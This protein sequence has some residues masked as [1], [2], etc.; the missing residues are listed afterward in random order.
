MAEASPSLRVAHVYKD[1]HPVRGGIEH[2]V[3]VLAEAQA[4]AGHAVSVLVANPAGGRT[5]TARENGVEVIRAGRWVTWASTPLSPTLPVRLLR[6][7]GD[8]AHLH[9]PHPP[10]EVALLVG[11][12]ARR[13]VLTVHCDIVRQRR[14]ARLYRPLLARVLRRVDR[15]VVTSHLVRD[16]LPW[17]GPV[18]DRVRVVPLGVDTDRFRPDQVASRGRLRQFWGVPE[19]VPVLLFVGRLRHYKGGDVLLQALTRLAGVHLVVVGDGPLGEPWRRLADELGV[20]GQVTFAGSVPDADLPDW[21]GAADLFVLPSTSSAEAFGT[22]L[23]E[24]MASGLA[25]VSTEVGTATSWVNVDGLTGRVV[26]PADPAP[27]AAAVRQL[28][29]DPGRCRGMGLAGR[30]RVE[31]E[32]SRAAMVAGVQSVYEDALASTAWSG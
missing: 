20:A 16:S 5:I 10:G 13:S 25:V 29:A 4:A 31:T 2:H 8:I 11:R 6:Q 22:V 17:L 15:V 18:L 27:L 23:L 26:P 28:L 9:F 19:D 7:G 24:A 32:F 30:A 3:Q 12:P 14:L 1:Y 21:Y